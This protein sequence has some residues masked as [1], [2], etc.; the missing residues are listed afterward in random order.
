MEGYGISYLDH[1]TERF[2]SLKVVACSFKQGARYV[3]PDPQLSIRIGLKGLVDSVNAVT[4]ILKLKMLSL[5]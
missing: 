1:T 5:E 3:T 2:W 4:C